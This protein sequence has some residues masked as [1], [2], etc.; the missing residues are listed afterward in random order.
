MRR[1]R[2][3]YQS[4]GISKYRFDE[5]LAFCR[6][7]PEKKAE[8]ETLLGVGSPSLSGMPHGSGTSDPVARAAEKRERLLHDCEVVERCAA[9]VADGRY[10]VAI[11]QNVCYG[12]GYEF[13][14]EYLPSFNRQY[15][16]SARRKFYFIINKCLELREKFDDWYNEMKQEGSK[17]I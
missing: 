12:K 11:I 3:D 17:A 1:Y 13:I 2:P 14:Q 5:L 4:I 7:Y 9:L 10:S 15:F 8:A 16:F 6:Q